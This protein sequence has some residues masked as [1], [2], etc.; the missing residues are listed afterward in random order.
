MYR[1]NGDTG[2]GPFCP[3]SHLFVVPGTL[4]GAWHHT[5]A[6]YEGDEIYAEYAQN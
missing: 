6:P 1:E 4:N 3:T 2:D 5:M